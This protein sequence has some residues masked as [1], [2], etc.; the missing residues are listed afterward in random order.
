[1]PKYS[2]VIEG[3]SCQDNTCWHGLYTNKIYWDYKILGLQHTGCRVVDIAIHPVRW[4]YEP[5]Q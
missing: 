2:Y 4:E 5:C 1:M 3:K